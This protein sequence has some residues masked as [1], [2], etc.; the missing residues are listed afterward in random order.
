MKYPKYGFQIIF[1]CFA[2]F[3]DFIKVEQYTEG[4]A[5]KLLKN[6][7][8]WP[9]N[10]DKSVYISLAVKP[11]LKVHCKYYFTKEKKIRIRVLLLLTQSITNCNKFQIIYSHRYLVC[12]IVCLPFLKREKLGIK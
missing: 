2:R 3:D 4:G 12:A 11:I 7:Q 5:A 6:H 10:E 9:K 8:I 1:N